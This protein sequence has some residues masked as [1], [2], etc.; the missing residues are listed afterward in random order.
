MNSLELLENG[1]KVTKLYK[2]INYDFFSLKKFKHEA[3]DS[4]YQQHLRNGYN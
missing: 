1:L 2:I 3:N 4:K